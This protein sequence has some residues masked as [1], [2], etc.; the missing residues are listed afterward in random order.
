[1]VTY[2]EPQDLLKGDIPYPPRYGD[3]TEMVQMAADEIDA[4][5]GHLYTTP[6]VLTVPP[7]ENRPAQLLLKHINIYLASGRIIMDMAAG[8]E[9]TD[10]HAYGLSLVK[11]AYYMLDEIVKGNISLVGAEKLE[12]VSTGPRIANEDP[13]SLVEAF[14]QQVSHD[15]RCGDL[16]PIRPYEPPVIVP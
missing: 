11:R 12:G 8:G 9:D 14:Y 1:M 7:S 16:A 5:I 4:Y 10:L 15:Q 2:C 6:I 13:Y 3:G